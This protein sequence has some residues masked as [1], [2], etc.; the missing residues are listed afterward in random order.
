MT[1]ANTAT[2][3][4]FLTRIYSAWAENKL[5]QYRRALYTRTVREL[6]NLSDQQLDDIGIARPDIKHK[7]YASVYQN[8]PYATSFH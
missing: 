7:A 4:G 8:A 2:R 3:P 6:E 1:Y 5:D